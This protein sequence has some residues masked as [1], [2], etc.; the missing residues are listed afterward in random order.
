MSSVYAKIKYDG[1]V[2]DERAMDVNHLAPSLLVLSDLVK[3][4]NQMINGERAGVR[5]LVNANLE[6]KCFELNLELTMTI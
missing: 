5:V 1:S 3:A 2:L 6:Q 4:T